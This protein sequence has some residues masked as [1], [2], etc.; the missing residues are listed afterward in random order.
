MMAQ[1]LEDHIKQR[2]SS[3]CGAHDP[4]QHGGSPGQILKLRCMAHDIGGRKD[5][6]L[7]V[8]TGL[9]ASMFHEGSCV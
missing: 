1:P 9:M 5:N 2:G 6:G 3:S 4:H 7:N 8:F